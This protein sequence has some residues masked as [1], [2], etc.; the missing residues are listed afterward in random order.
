[1]V[2]PRAG[3][4]RLGRVLDVISPTNGRSGGRLQRLVAATAFLVLLGPLSRPATAVVDLKVMSFNVRTANAN[5][6]VNDWDGNRKNLVEQ[7]IRNFGP[8]LVGFQEDLKRQ[9]DF[10][11]DQFP[12]YTVVGRGAQGGNDGE[13]DSV[14]YRNSR[15][16]EVDRGF[17]WLSTTPDVPGSESWGTAFP[18]MVTWLKLSDT[19]NPGFDFVIMNTHWDHV[20]STARVNSATLM[21]EKIHDLFS[22]IPVMVTGDFNADQGGDAYRRMR[23]LDDFDTVRN[24]GDTYREI[25]PGDA[26]T[27]GTAHGF[28]GIAGDGRIDWIL[29]DND[30]TTLDAAIVRTSYDGFYPSDHFP[31]TATIRPDITPE[32]AAGA[33]IALVS[34]VI[35]RRRSRRSA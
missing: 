29:H 12:G 19:K 35:G 13:Y 15:F 22:G 8:D 32:P 27:V 6:G 21:R 25:H 1:M 16:D 33:A 7:T 3:G 26:D 30:F 20:S 31:I 34:F 11:A 10:I 2:I 23:G 18:R 4:A 28:D 17:F 5:D 24:L 9:H 14:M